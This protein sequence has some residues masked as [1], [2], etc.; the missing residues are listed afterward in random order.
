MFLSRGIDTENVVHL[1]NR[2]YSAI[3]INALMKFKGKLTR[4]ENI[5]L[6]R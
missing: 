5:I 6:S 2:V 1:H 3:K 4:L